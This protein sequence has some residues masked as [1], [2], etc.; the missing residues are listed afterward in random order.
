MRLYRQYATTPGFPDYQRVFSK[1]GV[2]IDDG[3][4]GFNDAAALAMIREA[5]TDG[6]VP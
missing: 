6:M 3:K 5:I 1:L 2:E 4:F